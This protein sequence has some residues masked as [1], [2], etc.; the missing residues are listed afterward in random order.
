MPN[1]VT[2]VVRIHNRA[3][4]FKKNFFIEEEGEMVFDFN[5][6]IPMPEDLMITSGSDS[7]RY[8][9]NNTIKELFIKTLMPSDT[10]ETFVDKILLNIVKEGITFTDDEERKEREFDRVKTQAKGYFNMVRYSYQDWY[11]WSIDKWGTKWNVCDTYIAVDYDGELCFTFNTAWN[12]PE[13]IFRKLAEMGY[14]FTVAYADEDIGA[15]VG[16]IKAEDESLSFCNLEKENN[17]YIL[18]IAIRTSNLYKDEIT[19][20]LDN[21][22]INYTSEQVEEA[23]KTLQDYVPS[24]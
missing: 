13:G 4:E 6:V 5:K 16:L 23:I 24:Y 8:I 21:Y 11:D 2:N 22:A 20:T 17:P 12:T 15:N 14:E 3:E 18:A 9:D 10:Q 19:E 1:W 7:Y